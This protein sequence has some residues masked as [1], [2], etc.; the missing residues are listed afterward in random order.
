MA[1]LRNKFNLP[2]DQLVELRIRAINLA[3]KGPWSRVNN[4][5]VTVKSEPS[6]MKKPMRGE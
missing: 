3:G 6:E 5:G 2:F 4:V 1:T